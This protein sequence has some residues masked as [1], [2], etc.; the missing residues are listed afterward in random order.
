MPEQARSGTAAQWARENPTVGF[1]ALA[2]ESDTNSVKVGDGVSSYGQLPYSAY[3][4]P[5]VA[6]DAVDQ[7]FVSWSFDPAVTDD[8]SATVLATAG[9]LYAT[10]IHIPLAARVANVCMFV[11]AA[12][13]VLTTGQCFAGLHNAAGVLLGTS[14]DLS[15]GSQSFATAGAYKFPLA[16]AVNVT[17]GDYYVSCFFNGTTGPK[18]AQGGAVSSA[19]PNNLGLSAGT[20][21]FCT[22]AT[23]ATTAMVALGTQTASKYAIWAAVA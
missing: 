6:W 16:T 23:G 14:G 11:I 19:N 1:G 4:L 7:G 3:R 12:G 10:R 18:L 22:G 21:R 9:T 17:P 5:R 8:D 13:S 2:F 20:F 15:A